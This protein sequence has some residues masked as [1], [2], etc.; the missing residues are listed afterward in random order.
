M[1]V[2]LSVFLDRTRLPTLTA[3]ADALAKAGFAL[4]FPVTVDLEKHSGYLPVLL[5]EE[6]SGFEFF[7]SKLDERDADLFEEVQSM[8]PKASLEVNLVCHGMQECLT[9]TAAAAVLAELTGGLF[10]DPQSGEFL[11]GQEAILRARTELDTAARKDAEDVARHG[12]LPAGKWA[13]AFEQTIQRVNPDYRLSKDYR[14]QLVECIRQNSSGLFLSQNCV[15][16]HESYRHCFAVLLTRTRL[17]PVLHSP[18]VLG[19]RFDHNCTIARAYNQDYRVGMKWQVAPHQWHSEYRATVGGT[20]QWFE[21]TAKSA[22]K[23][24][25][26]IYIERLAQGAGRV[27]SLLRDAAS[28]IREWE[29][30]EE[31][32]KEPIRDGELASAFGEA[33]SLRNADW[34]EGLITY[35][36]ALRL[37]DA[38][39]VKGSILLSHRQNAINTCDEI[40]SGSQKLLGIP[41][42]FRNAAIFVRYVDDFLA[43]KEEL[44]QMIEVI[45]S[46]KPD[47]IPRND[48]PPLPD[49][50][51][52]KFWK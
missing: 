9:A 38:K 35:Y 32:L 22:E 37:A 4:S 52:W 3:W 33:F 12:K 43:V 11:Q 21:T 34:N 30:S 29:V 48:V 2:D 14:K 46:L 42:G 5:G 47:Q 50:P 1:S 13:E 17:S 15:K 6:E 10:S 25:Y 26:P 41:S 8:V 45:E 20:K 16:I 18:F 49:R 27:T 28:F 51:W 19:S 36:N 39:G 23:Y 44:P 24:L 7:I 31:S 40:T